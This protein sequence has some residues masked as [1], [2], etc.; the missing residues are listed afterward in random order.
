MNDYTRRQDQVDR[1][2]QLNM[3]SE[4]RLAF[5]RTIEAEPIKQPSKEEIVKWN[6]Q[7]DPSVRIWN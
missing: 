1:A 4:W 7:H 6:Q 2:C 5:L 3:E